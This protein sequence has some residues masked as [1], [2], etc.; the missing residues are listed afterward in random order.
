MPKLTWLPRYS[1]T[2]GL[3]MSDSRLYVRVV[4]DLDEDLFHTGRG[5]AVCALCRMPRAVVSHSVVETVE[6][7]APPVPRRSRRPQAGKAAAATLVEK[8][9]LL[10]VLVPQDVRAEDARLPP[11]SSDH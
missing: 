4:A 8:A 9:L 1:N 3:A 6:R 5:A 11:I 10:A 2:S 7:N